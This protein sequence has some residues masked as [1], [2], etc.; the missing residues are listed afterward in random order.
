MPAINFDSDE[1][2]EAGGDAAAGGQAAGEAKAVKRKP[3]K[4]V[5]GAGGA[6]KKAKKASADELVGCVVTVTAW[7]FGAKWAGRNFLRPAKAVLI[8]DVFAHGAN[9]PIDPFS[10]K[11]RG[12]T[13]YILHLKRGEL[14]EFRLEGADAFAPQDS[15]SGLDCRVTGGVRPFISP[16]FLW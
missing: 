13:D 16:P 8:G 15:G 1:E 9:R 3:A 10:F 4:A 5:A 7:K 14:E 11:M 6:A 12:D 2:E